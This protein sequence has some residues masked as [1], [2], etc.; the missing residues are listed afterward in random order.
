LNTL[1]KKTKEDGLDPNVWFGNVEHAAAAKIGRE[2]VTYVANI[3]KYYYAYRL[4][5]DSEPQ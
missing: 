1:R 4:I 3:A 5:L 2:T